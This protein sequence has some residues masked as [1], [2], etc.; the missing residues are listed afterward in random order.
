MNE[1]ASQ[2]DI[3]ASYLVDVT[4]MAWGEFRA[5]A[6]KKGSM[7]RAI[8]GPYADTAREAISALYELLKAL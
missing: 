2:A 4:Q 8:D 3:N 1:T 5:S 7:E 6:I